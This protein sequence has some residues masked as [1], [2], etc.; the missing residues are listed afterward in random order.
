M[1]TFGD[2]VVNDSNLESEVEIVRTFLIPLEQWYSS[3]L[4]IFAFSLP[5]ACAGGH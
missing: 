1:G 3:T 5:N 4:E 2:L